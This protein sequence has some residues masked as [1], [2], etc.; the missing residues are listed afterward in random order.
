MDLIFVKEDSAEWLFMWLTLELHEINKGIDEPCVAENQG[1]TW[2][3]MGSYRHNR[4]LI[5][6]FRHRLHPK[7]NGVKEYSF[8]ASDS[9]TDDQIDKKVKIT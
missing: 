9:F 8:E 6:S 1:E 7:T 2:Q 4:K 3:Y 5:H